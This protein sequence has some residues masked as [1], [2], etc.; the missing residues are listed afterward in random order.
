[1]ITDTRHRES[2]E[3]QGKMQFQTHRT[4]SYERKPLA[5]K[6]RKKRENRTECVILTEENQEAVIKPRADGGKTGIRPG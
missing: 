6:E 4:H 5:K 2:N 3:N 1:M